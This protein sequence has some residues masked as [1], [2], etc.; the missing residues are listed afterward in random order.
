MAKPARSK[1][2]IRW[3]TVALSLLTVLLLLVA[4]G[5]HLHRSVP[6]QWNQVN[7]LLSGLSEEE[8]SDRAQ[9]IE[10]L[11]VNESQGIDS[12]NGPSA[13][14]NAPGGAAVTERLVVIPIK[15]ANV[16][17]ATRLTQVLANQDASMPNG[18]SAPRVWIDGDE[19]VLSAKIDLDKLSGVVSVFIEGRILENGQLRLQATGVRSGRLP[20]PSG[21]VEAKL[22]EKVNRSSSP[23]IQRIGELFDGIVIDPVMESW[24]D[25]R[26]EIRLLNFAL[27]E[28]R[29]ELMVRTS[30]KGYKPKAA[31]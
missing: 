14:P 18:I 24:N 19:L 6:E 17:L 11:V 2:R 15:D 1:R 29:V 25:K 13:S 20:V 12:Q 4:Y 9:S 7:R 26:R 3:T 31:E 28:D 27:F 5:W 30:P 16:W 21:I 8:L 23:Q 10:T 22:R